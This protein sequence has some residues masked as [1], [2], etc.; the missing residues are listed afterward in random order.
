MQVTRRSRAVTIVVLWSWA[1]LGRS[2][3][4]TTVSRLTVGKVAC[5]KTNRISRYN[6]TFSPEVGLTVEVVVGTDCMGDQSRGG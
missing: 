4:A 6:P 3:L 2:L 1:N 5:L